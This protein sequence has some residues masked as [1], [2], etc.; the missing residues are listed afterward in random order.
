MMTPYPF[1]PTEGVMGTADDRPD[2]KDFGI[3]ESCLLAAVP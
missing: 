3:S 2:P 1:R